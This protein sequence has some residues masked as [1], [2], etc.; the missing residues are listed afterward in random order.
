MY[1]TKSAGEADSLDSLHLQGFMSGSGMAVNYETALQDPTL[2]ACIRVIS[3]TIST[4]PV[5]LYKKSNT[6]IGKEWI[7]DTNSLMANTL[8]RKPNQRQTTPEFIE[9]MVAQLM[10]YSEY[11]AIINKSP[12]GKIISIVPFNSPKQVMVQ[13]S[14]EALI[15]HCTTNDGKSFIGSSDNILHI[16]DLSLTT[17]RALDK[18]ATAKSTIGLSLAATKNAESYYKKGSRAGAFIQADGKLTD[19][20]FARL[21]KQFND[22]YAGEENAHKIAVLENGM[23]FIPNAYNLKDA[24][25]LESRNAAIRE[26]AAI[27]GVPVSLLGIADPNMKDIETINAFFYRSCLQ[28]LIAKIEARLNLALPREYAIKFDVSEYLKGDVKT[29]ADV[30]ELLFTRGLISRNEARTRMNMQADTT[31]N[32][33][34]I[35]SNNLVFGTNEDFLNSN[36]NN[37]NVSAQNDN[38]NTVTSN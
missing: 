30:T 27:Y 7:E 35:G 6:L 26:I 34:V 31:E 1:L 14:G 9:Q 4:L 13:E 25:V 37:N 19:D 12:N 18:I 8:G 36:N 15:Y 21:H 33:Y 24:Q 2:K 10:L 16:R 38:E 3:Q 32:I 17:F 29:Q 28:S 22:H 23:K 11:F 5:K 20:S